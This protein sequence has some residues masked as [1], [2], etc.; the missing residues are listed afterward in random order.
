MNQRASRLAEEAWAVLVGLLSLAQ[1]PGLEAG[2]ASRRALVVPKPSLPGHACSLL[3]LLSALCSQWARG[4]WRGVEG[5]SRLGLPLLCSVTPA[6]L[7]PRASVSAWVR[8]DDIASGG[9]INDKVQTER[10]APGLGW[11][12]PWWTWP[13]LLCKA[14]RYIKS[15]RRNC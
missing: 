5:V 10:P 12:Q 13:R 11:G 6:L 2:G 4:S 9:G 15:G 14:P 7:H 8:G 1:P 3:R